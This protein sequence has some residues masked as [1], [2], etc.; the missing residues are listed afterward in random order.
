MEAVHACLCTVPRLKR[1][2]IDKSS[3][4]SSETGHCKTTFNRSFTT[5]RRPRSGQKTSA[6]DFLFAERGNS[7]YKNCAKV[8]VRI[9][10]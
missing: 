1:S 2:R 8:E 6:V 7:R 10:S 5:R 4:S 9:P 3:R